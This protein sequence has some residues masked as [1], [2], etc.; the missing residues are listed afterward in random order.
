MLLILK[1]ELILIRKLINTI[2]HLNNEYLINFE[3]HIIWQ[4]IRISSFQ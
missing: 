3:L 1:T 4:G 2:S